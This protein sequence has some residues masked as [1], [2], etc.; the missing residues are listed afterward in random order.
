MP[1]EGVGIGGDNHEIQPR[2]QAPP[3]S[4]CYVSVTC[5]GPAT[6]PRP[7][8]L[9]PTPVRGPAPT[10]VGGLPPIP[11]GGPPPA[12][13]SV[14]QRPIWKTPSRGEGA[15]PTG[16]TGKTPHRINRVPSTNTRPSQDPSEC[17]NAHCRPSLMP[18]RSQIQASTRFPAELGVSQWCFSRTS[19]AHRLSEDDI[20][21]PS[22][23]RWVVVVDGSASGWAN[24]RPEN[25]CCGHHRAAFR[26]QTS[27][28][29]RDDSVGPLSAY[30]SAGD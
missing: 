6:Q 7:D 13:C 26:P 3:C 17:T 11:V 4:E 10:P 23:T 21:R 1:K 12:R 25:R 22:Q 16:E 27:H 18:T 9:R 14:F 30:L 28:S 20:T 8:R 24:P 29:C 19:K 15:A 5:A 2:H